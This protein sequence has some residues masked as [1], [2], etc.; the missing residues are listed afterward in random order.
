MCRAGGGEDEE[1]AP[2]CALEEDGW[3]VLSASGLGVC[4]GDGGLSACGEGESGLLSGCLSEDG[5]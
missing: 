1:G 4:V 2:V 5:L 3:E